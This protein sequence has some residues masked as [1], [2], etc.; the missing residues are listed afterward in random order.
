MVD[1]TPEERLLKDVSN[2]TDEEVQQLLDA[3]TKPKKPDAP[4]KKAPAK[5]W[6]D[7]PIC[8]LPPE[9]K[10]R[11]KE[12][13]EELDSSF[14]SHHID[15]KWI[16]YAKSFKRMKLKVPDFFRKQV[17]AKELYNRLVQFC[18]AHDLPEEIV[19]SI[20]PPLINYIHTGHMRP[21]IFVG[22]KGCGKTTAVKL[23]LKEALQIPIEV[24]K[25]PETATSHGITGDAG[26]YQSADAGFLAKAQLRNNTLLVGYLLDEIDKV[27]DT[28]E[29]NLSD[30]LLSITDESN[31]SVVDNYLEFPIVSLP[32]CPIF[33]TGNELNQVNPILADRCTV[34]HYP[35]ATASRIQSIVGK[36][37]HSKLNEET[38]SMI[39]FDFAML[40]K[41]I[42]RLVAQNIT[43]LRKHQE[44]VEIVLNKAFH[45]AMDAE[46]N[47]SVPVT[48]E[49]F[50][51]AE[52][53]L[54]NAQHRSVGF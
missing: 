23:L 19:G 44:L 51:S 36:Y 27:P 41:S 21:I 30:E 15:R 37:A 5:H 13:T 22:E 43:S 39:T 49:M 4:P 11:L 33:F 40:N 2:L 47:S 20:V 14:S 24:I 12:N 1:M 10:E 18:R 29:R 17:T 52:K 9:G 46:D 28:R 25:V 31:D 35:R 34:I 42:Q 26:I 38:Y 7:K 16:R 32:H 50:R 48:E 53:E 6:F 54:A 45:I 3:L 8:G